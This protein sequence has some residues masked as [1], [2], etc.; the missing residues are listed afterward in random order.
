MRKRSTSAVV[1]RNERRQLLG[2]RAVA[3][4][5]DTGDWPDHPELALIDT[6]ANVLHYAA[7]AGLDFDDALRIAHNHFHGETEDA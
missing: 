3:L 7:H 5:S 4:C 1:R 6:L 2:A